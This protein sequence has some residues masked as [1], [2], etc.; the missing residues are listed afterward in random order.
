[1]TR[2]FMFKI[3]TQTRQAPIFIIINECSANKYRVPDNKVHKAN[4]ALI[5][6]IMIHMKPKWLSSRIVRRGTVGS[7][8]GTCSKIALFLTRFTHLY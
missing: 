3:L 7:N 5:Q 8:C 2:T 4:N 1:M 6:Q